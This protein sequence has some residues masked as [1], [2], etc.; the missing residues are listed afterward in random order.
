VKI[1][2]TS[3]NKDRNIVKSK[4]LIVNSKNREENA[5]LFS[6]HGLRKEV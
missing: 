2:G 3:R 6:L 1:L 5:I 4:K